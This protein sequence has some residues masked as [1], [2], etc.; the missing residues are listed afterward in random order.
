VEATTNTK[1]ITI[2]RGSFKISRFS[3][4]VGN[5][6]VSQFLTQNL[7]LPIEK[8]DQEITEKDLAASLTITLHQFSEEIFY[9]IQ[10]EALAVCQRVEGADTVT[11]VLMKDGRYAVPLSLVES[12]A[13]V[14]HALAFNLHCFFVPGALETLLTVFPDLSPSAPGSATISSVRS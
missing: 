7:L 10:T 2:G 3:P 13:L 14:A 12:L 6:L 9:R 5:W 8:P 1:E 4:R 11:P